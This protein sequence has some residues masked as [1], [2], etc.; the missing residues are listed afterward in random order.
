MGDHVWLINTKSLFQNEK[1][2]MRVAPSARS[3]TIDD[4]RASHVD[5]V[6]DYVSK[7]INDTSEKLFE[8]IN[9]VET[10]T[11]FMLEH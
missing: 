10:N 1:Y 2:I 5:E 9:V 7:K 11:R 6:G 3:T 4:D 8:R